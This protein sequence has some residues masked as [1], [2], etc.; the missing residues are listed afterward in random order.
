MLDQFT[1]QGTSYRQEY[2][3]CNNTNCHCH[4]PGQDGHGPYW[5]A[6]GW[7][8]KR[9]YIGKQLPPDIS[10]TRE[11][12][13]AR[14]QEMCQH[15]TRLAAELDALHRLISSQDLNNSQHATLTDLGYADCLVPRCRDGMP[16]PTR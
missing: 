4:H 7:T 8:A 12:H 3:R 9:R 16:D 13:H 11:T 15:R 2:R 14:L 1:L 10:T 5:Y 6:R